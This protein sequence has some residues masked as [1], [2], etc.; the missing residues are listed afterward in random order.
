MMQYENCYETNCKIRAI[1]FVA[2]RQDSGAYR[3]V[4][5]LCEYHARRN[6]KDSPEDYFKVRLLSYNC[7]KCASPIFYDD[8]IR[9]LICVN[10]YKGKCTYSKR[11]D[12]FCE[13]CYRFSGRKYF[14][15]RLEDDTGVAFRCTHCG[16]II[17]DWILRAKNKKDLEKSV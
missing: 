2:H 9:A 13:G 17:Q 12:Y 6:T 16:H 14:L 8:E 15:K 3:D 7:P 4:K 5:L 10:N 11:A 1:Y